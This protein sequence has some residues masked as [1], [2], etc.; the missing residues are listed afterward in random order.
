MK[1]IYYEYIGNHLKYSGVD[2]SGNNLRSARDV[3][4]NILVQFLLCI[5]EKNRELS[6]E[7]KVG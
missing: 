6:V 4:K 7:I 3:F 1:F 5:N 2:L